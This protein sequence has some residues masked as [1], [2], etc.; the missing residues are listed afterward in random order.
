MGE[1]PEDTCGRDWKP[2][3]G[4]HGDPDLAEAIAQVRALGKQV[5]LV[6]FGHMHHRLRHTQSRLRTQVKNNP[7]GTI[8]LNAASVPRIV[9]KDGI[10]WRNF[11]LVKLDKGKVTDISLTW[12]NSQGMIASQEGLYSSFHT[13]GMHKSLIF[14]SRESGVGSPR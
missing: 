13:D 6:T 12:V 4:D 14:G 11:S 3:G 7:Q 1:K 2:L 8:Y 9:E 5:P 10:K